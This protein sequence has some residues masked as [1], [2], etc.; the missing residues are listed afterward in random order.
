M[1]L[2]YPLLAGA[3][4]LLSGALQAQSISFQL[5]DGLRTA[6]VT[7]KPYHLATADFNGDGRPDI[8]ASCETQNVVSVTLSRGA[9]VFAAATPYAVQRGPQALVATDLNADGRPDLVVGNRT[10][11]SISVLL[12]TGNGT[13]AAAT[14]LGMGLFAN[15]TH[16]LA[17]DFTGDSNPDIVAASTLNGSIQVFV[18]STA[19]TLTALPTMGGLAFQGITT[20]DID[21]NG[22]L[23]LL[24]S[25]P[26]T[27]MGSI[28]TL[29]GL[30]N[31]TFSSGVSSSLPAATYGTEVLA[32][33]FNQDGRT[34]LAQLDPNQNEVLVFLGYPF[35]LAPGIRF[36]VG[37]L[38]TA[39]RA[40]DLDGDNRLELITSN[41]VSNS[42]TVLPGLATGYF[43]TARHY[44]TS[45]GPQDVAVAD[46]TGDG[47]PDLLSA[48]AA[49]TGQHNLTLMPNRGNGLFQSPSSSVLSHFGSRVTL[50]DLNGDGL[51]DAAVAGGSFGGSAGDMSVLLGRGDGHFGPA[52]AWGISGLGPG[53]IVARDLTG[54]NRP[55][56]LITHYSNS[57]FTVYTNDG[58]GGFPTR[59]TQWIQ[60]SGN[61]IGGVTTADFNGDGRYDVAVAGSEPTYGN[62]GIDLLLNNNGQLGQAIFL[63]TGSFPHSI[64]AADVDRDGRPDL[65]LTLPMY[66]ASTVGVMRNLG[67]N[68]FAPLVTYSTPN[69]TEQVLVADVNGDQWPDLLIRTDDALQL[70]L[71]QAGTRFGPA[72]TFTTAQ[73]STKV[74][75]ADLNG[76]GFVD[77]LVSSSGIDRVQ[78]F[79]NVGNT[80]FSALPEIPLFGYGWDMAVGQLDGDALPDLVSVD[81]DGNS[82][83]AFLNTSGAGPLS[84]TGPATAARGVWS[85][86]PNPATA[87]LHL[88]A[89][90]GATAALFDSRGV[91][92]GQ[93]A[94]GSTKTASLPVG[95][96]A[97]GLYFLRV[98]A[99]AGQVL[100]AQ[101]IVLQ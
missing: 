100:S 43:G 65:V 1:L 42:V 85:A 23:D 79:Q 10:A 30:G 94:L 21:R 81:L 29:Y 80:S 35:G 77:L 92:V 22:Q 47:R 2:R 96:L 5:P 52:R 98:L 3:T 41:D 63:P 82:V 46:F 36:R 48:D 55:E 69:Q 25:Q 15:P 88:P 89:S 74:Q 14:S 27:P 9:G 28:R 33:D 91:R 11:A 54:D 60:R 26:G 67:N 37:N 53:F 99:P 78:V 44:L 40:A 59:N 4:V 49:S 38:P 61:G 76:D 66:N 73:N 95:H 8:A 84:A 58:Q 93:W 24:L 20:V 72:Q 64:E 39:M 90:G 57:T 7:G 6:P 13:F 97:R 62:F 45:G 56:I 101:R 70:R 51:L 71:N 16:L 12:N 83:A 87:L 50:A 34:D 18:G 75:A 32:T 17:G 68:A 86:Y 31:G 19:G